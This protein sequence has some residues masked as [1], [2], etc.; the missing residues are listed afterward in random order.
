MELLEYESPMFVSM[1]TS[2]VPKFKKVPKLRS[3]V[4]NVKR[5]THE[6]LAGQI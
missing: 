4:V 5:A 3:V 2:I 1:L 6:S